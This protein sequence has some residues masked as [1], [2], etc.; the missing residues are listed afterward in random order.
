[1]DT[2]IYTSVDSSIMQQITV[3]T[4]NFKVTKSKEIN[5]VIWNKPN[6]D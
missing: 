6:A 2:I 5:N 4:N 1:M 3:Q